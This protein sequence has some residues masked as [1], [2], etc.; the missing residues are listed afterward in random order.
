MK[1]KLRKLIKE[2]IKNIIEMKISDK[3]GNDVTSDIIARIERG[4]EK[5]GHTIKKSYTSDPE[6]RLKPNPETAEIDSSSW[7]V[8]GGGGEI[9]SMQW[10]NGQEMTPQ[11]IQNW[12]E[13]NPEEYDE[14][15]YNDRVYENKPLSDEDQEEEDRNKEMDA[16]DDVP[17]GLKEKATELGYLG[18]G[19]KVNINSLEF[20]GD[21]FDL[22]PQEYTPSYGQWEDG[23][24]MTSVELE[25]W[26][27]NNPSD[28]DSIVRAKMNEDDIVVGFE[29]GSSDVIDGLEKKAIEKLKA[30]S[31]VKSIKNM[32]TG[33]QIKG[34][35]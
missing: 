21:Y 32:D 13:A 33:Q 31:K 35:S 22:M 18:K 16:L 23:T 9:M 30:K 4:L 5:D 11:Q 17:S 14:M 8:D 29:D 7:S 27:D 10:E 19:K 24:E 3:D 26:A 20:N 28:V 25:N 34:D 6:L 2:E 1:A 15:M 12:S